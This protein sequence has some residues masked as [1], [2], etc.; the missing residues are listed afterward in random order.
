MLKTVAVAEEVVRK[1]IFRKPSLMFRG[2]SLMISFCFWV[3]AMEKYP[4]G[5]LD[6]RKLGPFL[7]NHK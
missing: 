5:R 7:V 2:S 4:F 1:M 6:K 3:R